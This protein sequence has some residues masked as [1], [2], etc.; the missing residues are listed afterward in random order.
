MRQYM[1]AVGVDQIHRAK[2]KQTPCQLSARKQLHRLSDR[3]KCS[4]YSA[5]PEE[6]CRGVDLV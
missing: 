1:S 2:K 6:K 4:I 3:S 5:S